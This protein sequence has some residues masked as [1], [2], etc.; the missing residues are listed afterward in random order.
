MTS[1]PSRVTDALARQYRIDREL[2][3]GGMATVVL[4]RDTALDRAVAVKLLTDRDDPELRERFLR[5]GRFAAQL[6]HP[7]VVAV[8]DTGEEDGTPY[9]VMELV[10]GGSLAD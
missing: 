3:R 7:N 1:I 10:A 2:G 8:Y 9:I 6:S 4:A 5:E